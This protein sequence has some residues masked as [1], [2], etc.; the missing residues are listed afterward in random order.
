[1]YDSSKKFSLILRAQIIITGA[2]IMVLEILGSRL[3]APYYG[4]TLFVWGSLIG[5]VLLGLAMGYYFGGKKSDA[6]ASYREF[7]SL[8]FITGIYTLF[9]TYA[10]PTLFQTALTLRLGE[11]YGPLAASI[12]LLAVPSFLLG[13]IAPYAIKLNTK[14]LDR[15]GTTSG[16]LYSLS[17]VGSIVGTFL[18]TFI[19]IPELGVNTILYAL[20]S[21]LIIASLFGLASRL[22]VAGI[23]LIAISI[24]LAFAPQI[25]SGGVVFQKETLYHKLVVQDDAITGI[26]TMLLDNNFHSGMDIRDPDRIVYLYTAYF[27]VAFAYN[28]KI[29]NVLFVGGGGFSA[30][31]KFLKEYP[32]VSIDVVEIDPDVVKAAKDYFFVEEYPRLHIYA[33]DGRVLLSRSSKKYDLIV[34][35]AYARTYIPF[36]LMTKEFLV[37]VNSRLTE[38]GV[39]VSNVIA[40]LDGDASALF[41]SELRT[42]RSVFPKVDVYP[43]SGDGSQVQNIIVIATKSSDDLSTATLQSRASGIVKLPRISEYLEKRLKANPNVDDVPVF[44][45]DF[46]PVENF[47]NPLT[48]RTYVREIEFANK[49]IASVAQTINPPTEYIRFGL[50]SAIIM[51]IVASVGF[52]TLAVRY[53]KSEKGFANRY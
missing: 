11:R 2:A 45:D 12:M 17:T 38:T 37:L 40:S 42:M 34:L 28:P 44:T 46:A 51:V 36:H 13:G 18:T 23:M 35:D 10:A 52:V 50:P 16:N 21:I 26:R 19:L 5:V 8:I 47:L 1:M 6:N 7:S 22:K 32:N 24:G 14:S 49:T 53:R 48:G 30:P 9:I 25:P 31:K 41:R 20:S 29:E 4:S 39:V 3:L 15:V 27:H 33:E 43:V